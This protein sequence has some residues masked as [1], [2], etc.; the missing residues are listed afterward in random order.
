M[1]YKTT[2]VSTR[3]SADA[4]IAE[5]IENFEDEEY[6]TIGFD[7]ETEVVQDGLFGFS[8]EWVTAQFAARNLRTG[9]SKV[10][11]VEVWRTGA[12]F[13]QPLVDKKIP[14]VA[15]NAGFEALV[16]RRYGVE[17]RRWE[18]TMLAHGILNLGT[19]SWYQS[20]AMMSRLRLNWI[21]EGK[22]TIQ[23][24]FRP[25]EELSDEQVVYAEL[26]ALAAM[27]LFEG[28]REE[29]RSRNLEEAYK[30]EMGALPGLVEMNWHGMPFNASQWRSEVL[31]ASDAH[32]ADA[33]AQL[34]ELT[35]GGG[36][37]GLFGGIEL[38]WNPAGADDVRKIFNQYEDPTHMAKILPDKKKPVFGTN[39]SVDTTALQRL[40]FAGSQLAPPLLLWR[41]WAKI[42]STYGEKI[43]DLLHEGAFHSS[44][45]QALV[46]TGRWASQKPNGQNLAPEMKAYFQAPEGYHFIMADY[47]NMEMRV[48]ASLA[49]DKNLIEAFNNDRDIHSNTAALMFGYDIEDFLT[50]I[51]EKDPEAVLERKKA[52]PVNFGNFYGLG[53]RSLFESFQAQGIDI[54]PKGAQELIDFWY[55]SYSDVKRWV[56]ARDEFV[57]QFASHAVDNVDWQASIDLDDTAR[58]VYGLMGKL[59]GRYKRRA[60]P[61]EIA[62]EDRDLTID[63]V[64]WVQSFGEPVML[65]RDGSPLEFVSETVSGRQ[66]RFRV[67]VDSWYTSQLYELFTSKTAKPKAL[68]EQWERAHPSLHLRLTP[69]RDRSGEVIAWSVSRKA[70]D[71]AFS[72]KALKRRF[73]HW[74]WETLEAAGFYARVDEIRR[75]ALND[76]IRVFTNAYRNAP[77]QGGA[78]EPMQA[79]IADL[80]QDLRDS[81]PDSFM[82]QTVHDSMVLVV[83]DEDVVPVAN[84]M[85][86]HMEAGFYRYFDK[87]PIKVDVEVGKTLKSAEFSET[88]YSLDEFAALP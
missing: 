71:M 31:T 34:S 65:G 78:A 5:I 61:D 19:L 66:R 87:V 55:S 32:I 7:I 58:K 33:E 14:L 76:R 54:T 69:K 85:V 37:M 46:S 18:D 10:A 35:G 83:P 49:D 36:Q 8:G 40:K 28:L 59:R 81:Y 84:L 15:H 86:K 57:K 88:T 74:A 20:L 6:C 68:L 27:F 38:P 9:W 77:V 82:I 72:N 51:R 42:R 63:E 44:Y 12:E 41:H 53:A 1:F 2:K 26:D 52:K 24:S 29:L 11:V 67:T 43:L 73:I 70:V 21:M 23:L 25:N 48:G 22:G 64:L 60:Y 47:S 13:M 16:L 17:I 80:W 56:E 62:A 30:L 45:N 50:R 75:Y 39:D 79:A 3:E 4:L